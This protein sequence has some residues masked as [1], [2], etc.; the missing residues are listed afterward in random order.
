[1]DL[2]K[3]TAPKFNTINFQD[4]DMFIKQLEKGIQIKL[5]PTKKGQ[6]RLIM[7]MIEMLMLGN[8]DY[9]DEELWTIVKEGMS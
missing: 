9:S 2:T 5:N 6:I 1:M 3:F 8:V 7:E 4:I